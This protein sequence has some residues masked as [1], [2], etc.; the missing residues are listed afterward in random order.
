MRTRS[1][2]GVVLVLAGALAGL[3]LMPGPVE[4]VGPKQE[5]WEKCVD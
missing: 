4:A 2:I 3:V 1:R 5:D